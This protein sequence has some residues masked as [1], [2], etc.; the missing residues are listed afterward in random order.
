[1]EVLLGMTAQNF[2][3]EKTQQQRQELQQQQLAAS[4]RESTENAIEA[5][6]LAAMSNDESWR[7]KIGSENKPVPIVHTTLPETLPE[8]DGYS[9]LPSESSS[10]MNDGY[11]DEFDEVGDD[12]E[13]MDQED[14]HQP[15]DGLL[16]IE[17]EVLFA[18][19]NPSSP[20]NR[21]PKRPL[22]SNAPTMFTHES[23]GIAHP[24]KLQKVEPDSSPSPLASPM[25]GKSPSKPVS[26]LEILKKQQQ[27]SGVTP[28]LS[29]NIPKSSKVESVSTPTSPNPSREPRFR[30]LSRDNTQ[31]F[32]I[33]KPN[34][35]VMKTTALVSDARLQGLIKSDFNIDG[36]TRIAEV[37]RFTQ[38]LKQSNRRILGTAVFLASDANSLASSGKGD[39]S[40]SYR[41]FCD[42]FTKDERAG[43]CTVSENV[44]VYLVPPS[45]KKSISLLKGLNLIG[46]QKLSSMGVGVIWAIV[47]AREKGPD[48]FTNDNVN[49]SFPFGKYSLAVTY[50][51]ILI[52]LTFYFG[53]TYLDVDSFVP[54]PAI[55]TTTSPSTPFV[56]QS[57]PSSLLAPSAFGAAS[58]VGQ[59]PRVANPTIATVPLNAS[60]PTALTGLHQVAPQVLDI[61]RIRQVAEE[62]ARSGVAA[63]QSAQNQPNAKQTMP[64]LFNGN[65]GYTEFM[66]ALKG[67]VE[68]NKM[69]KANAFNMHAPNAFGGPSAFR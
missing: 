37:E 31:F 44:Q 66:S 56:P 8:P 49:K 50:I 67:A 1:M 54:P 40:G 68:R 16:P 36:R 57:L 33:T 58:I 60:A 53:F 52:I 15:D 12:G 20:S 9:V 30:L 2:A 10:S 64:F 4:R 69:A 62:I 18:S 23:M 7:D 11:N 42:E 3:D 46:E 29:T 65:P 47:T 63:L 22:D 6:R 45:F 25:D 24:P 41:R 21:V 34:G 32:T 19:K 26:F 17:R 48:N 14:A 55:G 43:M 39:A 38:E 13:I 5:K 28:P 61:Q 51:S 35:I 59:Q 27:A